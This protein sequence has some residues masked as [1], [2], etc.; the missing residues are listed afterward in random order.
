ME[1]EDDGLSITSTKVSSC[2]SPGVRLS[3]QGD[4]VAV[5]HDPEQRD[6][7]E[8]IEGEE[9]D[10]DEVLSR[11]TNKRAQVHLIPPSRHEKIR[12]FA[13]QEK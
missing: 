7:R 5:F 2:G 13:V 9:K 8:R 11:A 4:I 10:P 3:E 1:D 12:D 6:G